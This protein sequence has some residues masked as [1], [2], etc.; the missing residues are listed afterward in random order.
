[1]EVVGEILGSDTDVG[2]WKYCGRHGASWFPASQQRR[3]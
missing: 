2:I 1:M 3:Q